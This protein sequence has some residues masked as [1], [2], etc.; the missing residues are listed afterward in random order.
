[1]TAPDLQAAIRRIEESRESHVA[2]RDH[3]D[4]CDYCKEHPPAYVQTRDEQVQIIAE[5]D[6][7]LAILRQVTA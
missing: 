1:M 6:N 2:W 7:V 4:A 3:L 5:Y